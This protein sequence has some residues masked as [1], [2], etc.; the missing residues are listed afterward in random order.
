MNEELRTNI[1]SFILLEEMKYTYLEIR[2]IKL[3]RHLFEDNI[4][5][6]TMAMVPI[7]R[8][9]TNHISNKYLHVRDHQSNS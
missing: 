6:L 9:G 5:A 4:G 1:S 2:G 8:P 3:H 7:K